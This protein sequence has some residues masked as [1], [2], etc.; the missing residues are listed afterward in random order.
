MKINDFTYDYYSG[1]NVSLKLFNLFTNK[2]L[3]LDSVG[4][5]YNINYGSIPIYSYCS[6]LYDAVLRGREMV[7]GTLVLNHTSARL[8]S[9]FLNEAKADKVGISFLNSAPFIMNISFGKS[10]PVILKDCVIISRGQ[11]IQIDSSNI[12]EEYNFVGKEMLQQSLDTLFPLQEIKKI[13]KRVA[14][15]K[16]NLVASSEEENNKSRVAGIRGSKEPATKVGSALE[17]KAPVPVE[18]PKEEKPFVDNDPKLKLRGY[19]AED[20]SSPAK[21][22]AVSPEVKAVTPISASGVKNEQA[23]IAVKTERKNPITNNE[24]EVQVYGKDGKTYIEKRSFDPELLKR[25]NDPEKTKKFL[26]SLFSNSDNDIPLDIKDQLA[27]MLSKERKSITN[28]NR[29]PLDQEKNELEREQA[30]LLWVATNRYAIDRR[31]KKLDNADIFSDPEDVLRKVFSGENSNKWAT[32]GPDYK[33]NKYKNAYNDSKNSQIKT[34]IDNFF[35][36]NLPNEVFTNTNFVH[37][38]DNLP[39]I[40]SWSLSNHQIV[41]QSKNISGSSGYD[42]V[43]LGNALF[44]Y[45]YNDYFPLLEKDYL[46][47]YPGYY[48]NDENYMQKRTWSVNGEETL[49]PEDRLYYKYSYSNVDKQRDPNQQQPDFN[50]GYTY[51]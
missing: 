5:S 22:T 42:S 1:V 23:T 37:V 14:F 24:N 41:D 8:I 4:I 33:N 15:A 25:S 27:Y 29:A 19:K 18:K 30:G 10:P 13:N 47:L 21:N 16:G 36:G 44:S 51:E 17:E 35:N 31:Y 39:K 32:Y 26:T 34:T 46:N 28:K 38:N 48:D 50:T 2:F 6:E 43:Y 20:P 45:G 49:S 9:D 12:L 7:Q 40:P 3:L 11:T